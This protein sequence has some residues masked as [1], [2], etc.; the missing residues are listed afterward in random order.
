MRRALPPSRGGR[1]CL[2]RLGKAGSTRRSHPGRGGGGAGAQGR[3]EE[4]AKSRQSPHPP[5][6]AGC[7]E[8]PRGV[9]PPPPV[10]DKPAPRPGPQ[11]P[12]SPR[13]T[14]AV[15]AAAAARLAAG[16][17]RGRRGLPGSPVRAPAPPRLAWGLRAPAPGSAVQD[18]APAPS[19]PAA[20]LTG[21]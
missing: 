14:R 11:L 16:T 13:A 15:A 19:C 7:W 5:A 18:P 12:R 17:P 1:H 21:S 6:A 4:M 8:G 2:R 20:P 9:A 3:E 10:S